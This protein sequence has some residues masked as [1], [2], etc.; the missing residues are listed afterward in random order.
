MSREMT[1]EQIEQHKEFVRTLVDSGIII[2]KED[3]SVLD[4]ILEDSY[5]IIEDGEY[6]NS[7]EKDKAYDN[8]RKLAMDYGRTLGQTL[9]NFGLDEEEYKL[10]KKVIMRENEY[11][12]QDIHIGLFVKDDY[13]DK[14]EAKPNWGKEKFKQ[15]VEILPCD[16]NTTTR[17][18]HLFGQYKVKGL[19]KEAETFYEISKKIVDVSKIFE[20][21]NNMGE[22]MSKDASNWIQGLD[23]EAAVETTGEEKVLTKQELRPK[24]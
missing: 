23:E 5:A 8:Y 12:R 17:I 2:N 14:M 13:F 1:P 11:D 16:I 7:E 3:S 10:L 20:Y 4:K 9:Y 19:G 15:G 6:A 18:S 21:Y 24:Q 22:Q